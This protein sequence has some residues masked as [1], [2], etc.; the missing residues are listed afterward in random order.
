MTTLHLDPEPSSVTRA[1]RMVTEELHGHAAEIIEVA[2]LAVSELAANAV[3][4]ARTRFTVDVE[5]SDHEIRVDVSDHGVGRP[6]VQHPDP[7]TPTGRG[8][9]IVE[10]ITDCWGVDPVAGGGHRIWFRL[11][12]VPVDPQAPRPP[13]DRAASATVPRQR[14]REGGGRAA[15]A[16][17]A[18]GRAGRICGPGGVLRARGSRRSTSSRT[19]GPRSSERRS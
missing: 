15:S 19:D 1:R 13:S 9:A 8:L 17:G 16:P 11:R 6:E 4:H 3:R 10:R 18:E 12:L 7:S 5:C 14:A 2:A